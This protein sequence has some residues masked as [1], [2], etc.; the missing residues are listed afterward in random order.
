VNLAGAGLVG[1]E[2]ELDVIDSFLRG[3]G[4]LPAGLV[5]EGSPGIGKTTLWRH[6]VGAAGAVRRVLVASPVVA[7]ADL[8]FTTLADLLTDVV[9]PVLPQLAPP[10]RH[11]LE[12]AL[13]LREV[14]G[15]TPEPRAVGFALLSALKILA[16]HEALMVAIDDVQWLDASSESVLSFAVR[17][18][19]TEPV[20]FFL[21]RRLEPGHEL[22]SRLEHALDPERLRRV[23][24]GPLTFGA[25]QRMLRERLDARLPRPTVRRV[26]EASGGNPFFALEIA[27]NLQARIGQIAP[28][29]PLPVSDDLSRLVHDRIV[30][31]PTLDQSALWLAAAAST[32][33]VDLV[34]RALDTKSDDLLKHAM[35]AR[36]VE[37]SGDRIKFT[38]PLFAS[39]VYTML[40]A[41]ERR[42]RHRRLAGVLEDPEERARHLARA[43]ENPDAATAVALEAAATRA[44]SR[45]T[46]G[47]AAELCAEAVRLT[48]VS[49]ADDH[50]RR[51][52]ACAAYHFESGDTASARRLLEQA[53][54]E[55]PPG[56][57]RAQALSRLARVQLYGD[58]PTSATL[59]EQGLVE[60]GDD[61]S[62]R[63]DSEEGLALSL[64]FMREDLGKAAH[65]ASAAVGMGRRMAANRE[66]AVALGTLGLIH[67]ALGHQD[68]TSVLTEA[69]ALEEW[70]REERLIRQPRF[71]LG[72]VFFWQDEPEPA[73]ALLRGVREN[74]VAHGDESSLPLVLGYL[75]LVE[76]ILG[77]WSE[78]ATSAEEAYEIAIQTDQW[79]EQA[80]AL[81]ARALVAAGLGRE[82]PARVDAERA[83]T[84]A[85]P[86]RALLAGMTAA[87]ALGI[88]DLSLE[89]A[90]G[91]LSYL[92][93]LVDHVEAAGIREFGSARFVTDAVEAMI[94]L[95]RLDDASTL[96]GRVETGAVALDR[97]SILA[98]CARCRGLLASARGDARAAETMFA[99]ALEHHARTPTPFERART[100]FCLGTA[101]R[102]AGQKREAREALEEAVEGF[103]QLG[104]MLWE[105]RATAE[106]GRIGGRVTAGGELTPTEE[107]VAALVAQGFSNREIAAR[108]FVTERTVEFHLSNMY[109]KLGVRS[110]TQLARWFQSRP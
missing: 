53:V 56:A 95:Q 17:R 35:T 50:W 105:K 82:E 96:L 26:W 93:P 36:I 21:T 70:S 48:P 64:F 13:L 54:A 86:R 90:Q 58:R 3:A 94:G 8:S 65:H 89:D 81:A 18:L 108:L 29:E 97:P 88:L 92:E 15:S 102:R 28:G 71:N 40:E 77:K 51:L 72:V 107:R 55:A 39:A 103:R 11:A 10:Q 66:L 67:G 7:E 74:A 32:P 30:A 101:R 46:T 99:G 24:V 87:W 76:W 85:R 106:L 84:L 45:G 75:T 59:F 4:G 47:A 23:C 6:G 14:A 78:A 27:R 49:A 44:R 12:V 1:R 37:V 63:W 52:T 38:H 69:L 62:V 57:R 9:E 79:T 22:P 16:S 110:R 61:L 83:L 2:A 60:A 98:A 5:L 19:K 25:L 41:S 33:T 73:L 91:A 31:L 80:F 104:A 20:G 68:A 100:L 43:A 42:N 109:G 34:R